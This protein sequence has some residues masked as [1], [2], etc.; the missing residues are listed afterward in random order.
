[1]DDELIRVAGLATRVACQRMT[2][3]YLKALSDSIEQV[4]CLSATFA[5]DRKA[6]AYAEIVNL[7][8]DAAADPVLALLARNLPG[9]LY[10]LIVTVGPA[11]DDIIV[12]S[13]HRLLALI[14]AGD[15]GGAGREMEQHLEGLSWTA[16]RMRW[17]TSTRSSEDL[18][19][20][21]P[22]LEYG[23]GDTNPMLQGNLSRSG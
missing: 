23:G 4:C 11:A 15:A 20:Q 9:H 19:N 12:S 21:V 2:P 10:E 8:A 3:R 1:M 16:N 13:R 7:L 17:W 6:T 22:L 18:D 14:R 5:W